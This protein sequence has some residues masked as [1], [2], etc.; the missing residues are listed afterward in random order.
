MNATIEQAI[1]E[2]IKWEMY[3]AN[4]YLSMSAWLQDEGLSGFANWM[5]VQYQE[6][7]DHALKFYDFILSRGGKVT[8]SQ[9]DAPPTTW[10][11]VLDVFEATLT[12][13]QEV[14]RRINELTYLTKEVKDF[15]SD[16]F[17]QW[18]VT[19]QIE[20]EENVRDILNKL[21][22]IK[23]EGQ[24]MLMLDQEMAQRVYTPSTTNA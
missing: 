21:R 16:I 9:I 11:S 15:A 3:S 2:Q 12:H 14:T 13:E 22:L 10:D 8:L 1:N 20:E 19:E 6:E 17:M 5:R 4:L 7:T 24:G 23:G 18:F